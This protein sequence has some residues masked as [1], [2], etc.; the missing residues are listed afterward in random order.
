V[1]LEAISVRTRCYSRQNSGYT[2]V[3]RAIIHFSH[4]NGFPAPCYRSLFSELAG[5]FE[6][7]YVD[8]IGHDPRYPVTDGWPNLVDEVLDAIAARYQQPV[9]GIGHSLGGFL[10]ALAAAT[11]PE[12]FQAVILLDAPILAPF[13]GS[14]VKLVKRVGLI[15][16]VTPAGSTRYRRRE[17]PSREQALAHFK[18]RRLFHRF[19]PE[20]LEDYAHYGLVASENGVALWF[21]PGVE[22]QIYRTIPHNIAAGLKRFAVPG[23]FIGGRDSDVLRRVGLGY[24]RRLFRLSLLA[25]GHLFPFEM[26]RA[27]ATAISRMVHDLRVA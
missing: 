25:G 8:R 14:A 11:R 3:T 7:G 13:Q 4:A 9:I 16:R 10:T 18:R 5:E 24:T 26:P 23:G 12:L 17:W 22:Y 1:G 15:D 6:I 21:D 19:A 2:A 20:A 27:A